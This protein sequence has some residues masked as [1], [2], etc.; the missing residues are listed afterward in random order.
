[1]VGRRRSGRVTILR[2]VLSRS[3]QRRI[4]DKTPGA[5]RADA[6]DALLAPLTQGATCPPRSGRCAP[7]CGGSNPTPRSCRTATLGA[8]GDLDLR[9]GAHH[10]GTPPTWCRPGARC[11]FRRTSNSGDGAR[12][13]RAAHVVRAPGAGP[14]RPGRAGAG[15]GFLAPL[16]GAGG[17]GAAARAGAADGHRQ[18]RRRGADAPSCWRANA[19]WASWRWTN[20]AAPRRCAWASSCRRTSACAA[21]CEA[22][23]ADPSRH[24]TLE[25]WAAESA[26]STAHR[27]AAVPPGTRHL[28]G[29]WRQQVLL[30]R[31]LTLAA[32]GKPM[33]LIASRWAMPAPAPSRPWCG[34]RWASRPAASSRP[35]AE[36]RTLARNI[37]R[38]D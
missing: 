26:A 15:P 38:R 18:G 25:G 4:S 35:R 22:V 14:C 21:L 17:V 33:G 20:C 5:R 36:P 16:P 27:G 37:E 13:R 34:A 30:A 31:A 10:R 6:R 28:F 29:P 9:R 8:G 7:S 2:Q 23:L 1:M 24:A 12:S 32:Q 19:V 11:G 3:C